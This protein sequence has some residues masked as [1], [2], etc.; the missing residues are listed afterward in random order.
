MILSHKGLDAAGH[1]D[2]EAED[3]PDPGAAEADPSEFGC[4]QP[5]DHRA[6]DD[7]HHGPGELGQDGRI[8]EEGDLP[9]A[10]RTGLLS[11]G[12]GVEKCILGAGFLLGLGPI[13]DGRLKGQTHWETPGQSLRTVGPT[14]RPGGP[15][16]ARL[17]PPL[18]LEHCSGPIADLR[19]FTNW[20]S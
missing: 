15:A 13:S 18:P 7:A 20:G 11:R 6:I 5:A 14:D 2:E 16:E 10:A 9:Q 1:A 4:A 12:P 8:G 3:R 17:R 19:L